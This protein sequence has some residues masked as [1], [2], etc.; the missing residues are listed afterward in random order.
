MPKKKLFRYFLC[1]SL[2]KMNI[3]LNV[4]SKN[5]FSTLLCHFSTLLNRIRSQCDVKFSWKTFFTCTQNVSRFEPSFLMPAYTLLMARTKRKFFFSL[6]LSSLL[7][8]CLK[9]IFFSFIKFP[10]HAQF[11]QL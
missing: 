4:L 11:E 7:L 9:L 6:F 2:F 3:F 1:F 8:I 5:R 10:N